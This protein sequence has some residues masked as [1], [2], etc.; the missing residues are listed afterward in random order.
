ML[1]GDRLVCAFVEPAMLGEEFKTWKLHITIVPWFRLEDRSENIASGLQEALK[2]LRP[3]EVTV[4][5]KTLFGPK[6]NRPAHLVEPGCFP[7][8]ETKVR[9]FFHKKRAW[10]VDET[11]K[12]PRQFRPHVTLQ[13]SAQIKEDDTISCKSIYIVE[14]KGDY[15][16]I[17]AEVNLG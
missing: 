3:F 9:H 13:K 10:L 14:Q 11:T 6:K 17:T 4:R 2:P 16:V 8:I 7:E 15:K 1:P 12:K 5:G